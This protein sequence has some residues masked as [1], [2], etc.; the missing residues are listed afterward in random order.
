MFQTLFCM[1]SDAGQVAF[2]EASSVGDAGQAAEHPSALAVIQRQARKR[3]RRSRAGRKVQAQRAFHRRRANDATVASAIA[4]A[5]ASATAAAGEAARAVAGSTAATPGRAAPPGVSARGGG[6]SSRPVLGLS[7]HLPQGPLSPIGRRVRSAAAVA[8]RRAVLG[9]ATEE[10]IVAALQPSEYTPV[11]GMPPS[12][13]GLSEQELLQL[14]A[15]TAGTSARGA[16]GELCPVCQEDI[17]PAQA[18]LQLPCRHSF[19]TRCTQRWL[20]I[21][22]RCPLC[23]L[24]VVMTVE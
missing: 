4:H 9:A 14:P 23:N 3:G 11:E 1:N 7:A 22:N 5:P 13:L 8:T 15:I 21:R 24:C 2:G 17:L 12:G 20:R 6:G 19:H 16:A 18:L 10:E